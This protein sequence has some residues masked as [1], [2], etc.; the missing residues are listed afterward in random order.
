MFGFSSK[1]RFL[2]VSGALFAFAIFS[3][4]CGGSI[5][6]ID[7]PDSQIL[8][9]Y[10]FKNESF[11]NIKKAIDALNG[12]QVGVF[13]IQKGEKIPL[14]LIMDTSYFELVEAKNLLIAKKDFYIYMDKKN[15]KFLISGDGKR[16]APL[17]D[18]EAAKEVLGVKIV[19]FK[20]DFNFDNNGSKI[21]FGLVEGGN[22]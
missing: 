18:K 21:M 19:D 17:S 6:N 2:I 22:K 13:K 14:Y 20:F 3:G 10:K 12:S 15:D 16:W 1:K 8:G 7:V 11:E 5:Q 9:Y 4:G